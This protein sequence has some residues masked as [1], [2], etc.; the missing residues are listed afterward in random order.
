A[1]W[2]ALEQGRYVSFLTSRNLLSV[3]MAMIV[4]VAAINVSS[5]L[6]LLVV[7]KEQEIAILRATGV[8]AASVARAFVLAGLLIGIAGAV[9]GAAVG[10]LLANNINEVLQG[11]EW[12]VSVL[13]G[14]AVTL[15]SSDFYLEEIPVTLRFLPVFVSVLFTLF[16]ALAAGFLP[17][18][19]ASRI[20]P[21][22]ILRHNG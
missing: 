4:V 7:E 16:V 2:Y 18:R 13:A 10:L 22:R 12:I 5:A 15:L 6:V 8:D 20:V 17:A 3:V 1:N 21:D 9:I 14:R 11:I 19:R